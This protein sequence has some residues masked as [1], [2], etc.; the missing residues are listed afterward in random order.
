M[1]RTPGATSLSRPVAKNWLV[2][3][4]D[5]L[6]QLGGSKPDI[7]RLMRGFSP[8]PRFS[9]KDFASYQPQHPS[10]E[11]ASA[12]LRE[13]AVQLGQPP[14][15]RLF[16]R[17]SSRGNAKRGIYLDGGF[18]VGKTHLLAALWNAVPS[19]K[20]YLS[21]DELM[22]VIGLVGS[23][24]ATLGF[25]GSSL[26]AI[27]EWE[28]DDPGNLKMAL[29]FLRGAIDSGAFVAVTSN[30]LPLELGSG[31]FSQKDFRAEVEELATA[32][33]VLRIEGHDYRHRHFSA[34]FGEEYSTDRATVER[35][36]A[37][38]GD[39]VLMAT[40][41]PLVAALSQLH[42]IRYRELARSI[43]GLVLE[44]VRPLQSLSDALRWV[45]FVDSIYDNGV[46]MMAVGSL[47]LA[48]LF[49][50]DALSG[51]YA[52][53]CSRCLSRMEELLGEG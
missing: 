31:R 46:W 38:S 10:Q 39:N 18:G 4:L 24:Q 51:P 13:L 5:L 7:D 36:L 2:L 32:F 19:P 1:D 12:R 43:S 29:A 20:S 47:S 50:A 48:N 28:L 21:F 45:H 35:R 26:I 25:R 9:V 15:R 37:N 6:R 52:K 44:E 23:T 49:T 41:E 30:T 34:T 33:E 3:T 42:P 8:P 17:S 27:D 16:G 11:A 53:K 40:F 22:Y 14:K